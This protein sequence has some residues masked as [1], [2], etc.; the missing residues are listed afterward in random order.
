[1]INED[2][3]FA[4]RFERTFS[5]CYEAAV[6]SL[7]RMAVYG[8]ATSLLVRLKALELEGY[9]L[10]ETRAFCTILM[11]QENLFE[12]VCRAAEH[13]TDVHFGRVDC[14]PIHQFLLECAAQ[15]LFISEFVSQVEVN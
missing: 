3:E 14:D 7:F 8:D 5:L 6:D 1:V 4:E 10:E 12:L 9:D 11:K 15:E 13:R 2:E